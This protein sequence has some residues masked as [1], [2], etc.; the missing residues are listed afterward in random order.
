[1]PRRRRNEPS[2]TANARPATN[3]FSASFINEVD[4]N[5]ASTLALE[6]PLTEEEKKKLHNILSNPKALDAV[7]DKALEGWSGRK[8]WKK[9][10][11]S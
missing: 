5:S 6:D 7:I 4:P 9:T 11:S 10:K 1:M 2:Y 8:V 3:E